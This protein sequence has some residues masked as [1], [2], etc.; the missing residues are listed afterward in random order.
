MLFRAGPH[1]N[2]AAHFLL[3]AG[4]YLSF[5]PTLTRRKLAW[6]TLLVAAA[7]IHAYLLAMVALLWAANLT[8]ATVKKKLPTTRALLEIATVIL[9]TGLFCWQAGYFSVGESIRATGYGYYHMNLLS[10]IDP[11]EHAYFSGWSWLLPNIPGKAGDYEGFNYLG[12]GVIIGFLLALPVLVKGKARLLKTMR[13]F[14]FLLIAFAA[15][16]LYAITNQIAFGPYEFGF[17]IPDTVE[18]V[19]DVFRASGRMFWPVYYALFCTLVFLLVRGYKKHTATLLLAIVL[20][21]QALDIAASPSYHA[22][23]GFWM[24]KKGSTWKTPLTAP[25]WIRAANRYS[26]VQFIMPENQPPHWKA[27]AY[28]AASHGLGTNVIYLARF[29]YPALQKARHVAQQALNTGH[30][31]QNTLYILGNN[32][33]LQA[34]FTLNANRD[35]WTRIDGV[36]VIAPGWK[37]CAGCPQVD[38]KTSIADLLPPLSLGQQVSLHQ[39]GK[40]LAYLGRGW[41]NPEPWGTWSEGKMATLLLPIPDGQPPG[42]IQLTLRPLVS[43]S[44]PAQHVTILVNGDIAARISLRHTHERKLNVAVPQSALKK[45]DERGYLKLKFKLPDAAR[46]KALGLNG[47]TRQLA[48]GLSSLTLE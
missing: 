32:S 22:T 41:S 38:K 36:N 14:P 25:F 34:H 46:P 39:S 17:P 1:L 27:L 23:R 47:D 28:Y 35:L 19:A 20:V 4:L 13:G 21:I 24:A 45:A 11:S 2:L 29:D 10:L 31:R 16:T 48:I 3:L 9:V 5:K 30:Y 12:L 7:L 40:G 44:H 8:D 42:S 37:Q 6:A 15:L 43:P 33:F 18:K 26:R